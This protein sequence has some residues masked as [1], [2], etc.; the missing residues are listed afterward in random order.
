MNSYLNSLQS[1]LGVEGQTLEIVPV[2]SF[3]KL[4]NE[5]RLLYPLSELN[6]KSGVLYVLKGVL[7]DTM[8]DPLTGPFYIATWE[9]LSAQSLM[10]APRRK[11]PLNVNGA[12]LGGIISSMALFSGDDASVI[13]G[14]RYLDNIHRNTKLILDEILRRLQGTNP[15]TQ[16][17]V[18]SEQGSKL[19]FYI[20][21]L[22]QLA[23]DSL[24]L[25]MGSTLGKMLDTISGRSLM[26]K[27]A[28]S[29]LMKDPNSSVPEFHKRSATLALALGDE[30]GKEIAEVTR[31]ATD[32]LIYVETFQRTDEDINWRMFR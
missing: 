20:G 32:Y 31:D 22:Y 9:M 19:Q 12:F 6:V 10:I 27:E 11:I 1:R 8:V 29:F 7:Q 13:A 28:V 16:Y 17:E 26:L 15:F 14:E 25:W 18:W 23:Y 2:G 4:P 3:S 21:A 30:L 24:S 5:R